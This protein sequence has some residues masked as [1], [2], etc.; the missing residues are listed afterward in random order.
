[1]FIPIPLSFK[2]QKSANTFNYVAIAV[3]VLV[4]WLFNM[5]ILGAC[6]IGFSVFNLVRSGAFTD[7]NNR[8]QNRPGHSPDRRNEF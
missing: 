3:G 8:Q 4:I 6:L 1:M 5:W 2:N 7:M